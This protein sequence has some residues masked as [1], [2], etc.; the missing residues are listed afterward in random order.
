MVK[1]PR[2][3]SKPTAIRLEAYEAGGSVLTGATP[4]TV[5][6]SVLDTLPTLTGPPVISTRSCSIPVWPG[7]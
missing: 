3:G 1:P 4:L 7:V 5:S 6:A 2:A